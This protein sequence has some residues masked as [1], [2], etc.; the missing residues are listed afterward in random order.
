MVIVIH[1]KGHFLLANK[2]FIE[3]QINQIFAGRLLCT[4]HN[5]IEIGDGRDIVINK[6]WIDIQF[7]TDNIR[8]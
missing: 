6:G 8:Y 5:G 3:V 2:L 4:I 1:Y 7:S